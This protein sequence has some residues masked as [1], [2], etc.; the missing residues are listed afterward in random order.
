MS[1][2]ELLVLLDA[3]IAGTLG[4]GAASYSIGGRSV[5]SFSL[6][7]LIAERQKVKT[8]IARATG[9]TPVAAFQSAAGAGNLQDMED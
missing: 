5:Q 6:A 9:Y 4:R 1:D 8:R 7:E 2:A 3:A